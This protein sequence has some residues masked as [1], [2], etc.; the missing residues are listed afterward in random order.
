[1]NRRSTAEHLMGY[2]PHTP[3]TF[4]EIVLADLLR[5]RRLNRPIQDEI[6]P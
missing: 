4:R 5:A 2:L 1:M 6:D 3:R